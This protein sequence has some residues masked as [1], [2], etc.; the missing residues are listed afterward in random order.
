[1]PEIFE[2]VPGL[3][4]GGHLR[5]MPDYIEASFNVDTTPAHYKTENV[6]YTHMPIIDGPNPGGEWL[7]RALTVLSSYRA[8]GL[9]TYIHCQAGMS[10]SV[11]VTAALLIREQGIT[12]KEA[13]ALIDSKSHFAD[14][15]PAFLTALDKFYE[16][17]RTAREAEA[18]S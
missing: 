4:Q 9:K 14:P 16:K 2:V 1:M 15:A 10:R 13:I 12:R 17:E 18:F 8:S 5:Y 6:Q 7:E 3:Y 11:F